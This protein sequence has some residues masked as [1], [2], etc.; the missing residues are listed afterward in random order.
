MKKYLILFVFALYIGSGAFA[1]DSGIQFTDASWEQVLEQAAK[2]DKIIFMDAF[3]DWCGPCKMMSKEVFTQEQVGNFYNAEFINVKMDMEKGE[4]PGLA[5]KYEV[6]AYP[7]LLF[8]NSKGEV[9][10]R[11]LGYHQPDDFLALGEVAGDPQNNLTGLQKSFDRGNRKPELLRK[12]VEM[13][14]VAGESEQGDHVAKIYLETQK[15]WATPENMEF[16]YRY[17]NDPDSRSMKFLIENRDRFNEHIGKDQVDY[18][19]TRMVYDLA[20][21]DE[22]PVAEAK[23]LFPKFFPAMGEQLGAKFQMNFDMRYGS[24]AEYAASTINYFDRY[25]STDWQ[26]L[27]SAA[28]TFYENIE[29]QDQLEKAVE[30]AKKS[31]DLDNNYYNNDTLAWLYFKTGKKGKAKKTAKKAIELAKAAGEDASM[32]EELLKK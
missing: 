8:I 29:D 23:A 30:W 26:E 7:T 9:V 19:L 5:E 18:K 31:V 24:I 22:D 4:G 25:E 14:Y 3:A 2:E 27:N 10:H 21:A 12:L 15:D 13:S 20:F 28:W 1:Q 6:R 16:I 32:T 11:G 17:A